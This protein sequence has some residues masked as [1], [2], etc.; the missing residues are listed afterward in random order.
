[1]RNKDY[2]IV[3]DCTGQCDF[4]LFGD[5]SQFPVVSGVLRDLESD[6]IPVIMPYINVV[7]CHVRIILRIVCDTETGSM[8]KCQEIYLPQRTKTEKTFLDLRL[9]QLFRS[10][11]GVEK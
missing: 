2:V 3:S 11:L 8:L 1:M 4:V 9:T 6:L 5:T 10:D 7:F